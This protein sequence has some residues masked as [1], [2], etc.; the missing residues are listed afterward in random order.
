MSTAVHLDALPG[1]S[2]RGIARQRRVWIAG[3]IFLALMA[4]QALGFLVLGT[5]QKGLGLSGSILVLDNLLALGC[6]WIAYRQ[7]QGVIALFWNISAFTRARRCAASS[8]GRASSGLGRHRGSRAR[9][10]WN[11]TERLDPTESGIPAK[12][13]EPAE[14]TTP[15]RTETSLRRLFVGASGSISLLSA[16]RN[17]AESVAEWGISPT[18][19]IFTPDQCWALRRGCPHV[20]LGGPT[21]P[22]CA[23]LLGDGPAVCIPLIANGHAIGTLSVQDNEFPTAIS[24]SKPDV[25]EYTFDRR[26]QLAV[27]VAEHI[28]VTV[29]NLQLREDLRLQAVRDPLT[30]LYNR[31]YM[32]EFLDRELHSARRKHRPLAVMMLDLDHFKR[33]ND[34]PATPPATRPWPLWATHF[35]A[36][37]AQKTWPA[38]TGAKNSPSSSPSA[39]FDRP[40]FAPKKFASVSASFVRSVMISPITLSPFRSELQRLTKPPTASTSF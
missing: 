27:A 30:G 21:D 5:G 13:S 7:A 10:W 3:V 9:R 16:S 23:H 26:R 25:G 39:P 17:R 11:R 12:P 19:Q 36:P 29:A 1:A 31:R 15:L 6:I 8:G 18:E 34:N 2:L 38:A 32:Q 24:D 4:A 33:Y 14:R 20:H 22:R 35:S 28:A 37:S 40:P